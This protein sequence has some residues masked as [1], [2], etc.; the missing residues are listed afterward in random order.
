MF[1]QESID[2]LN[3]VGG[4]GSVGMCLTSLCGLERNNECF[5]IS[6]LIHQLQKYGTMTSMWWIKIRELQRSVNAGA[7]CC[8]RLSVNWKGSCTVWWLLDSVTSVSGPAAHRNWKISR[9][10]TSLHT[11]TYP[12]TLWNYST[13]HWP[14]TARY[15]YVLSVHIAIQVWTEEKEPSIVVSS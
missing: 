11:F 6:V 14:S 5:Q 2:C 15:Q 9:W 1:K 3:M 10:A 13:N 4:S 7:F 8:E 12:T